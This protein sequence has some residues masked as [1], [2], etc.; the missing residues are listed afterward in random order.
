M[1]SNDHPETLHNSLD[2]FF[3]C[4][5]PEF[6]DLPLD[7]WNLLDQQYLSDG[8]LIF[9]SATPGLTSTREQ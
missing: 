1:A 2:R 6:L 4:E 8:Y 3:F 5:V 7:G 9:E